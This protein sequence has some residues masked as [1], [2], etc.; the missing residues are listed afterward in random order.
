M[1]DRKLPTSS[2]IKLQDTAAQHIEHAHALLDVLN[3]QAALQSVAEIVTEKKLSESDLGKR[4]NIKSANALRITLLNTDKAKKDAV[5]LLRNAGTGVVTVAADAGDKLT[6]NPVMLTQNET[7]LLGAGPKE[8]HVLLRGSDVNAAVASLSTSV[9]T[10]LSSAIGSVSSL[11]TAVESKIAGLKTAL[12]SELDSKVIEKVKTQLTDAGFSK[13]LTAASTGRKL[14][15]VVDASIDPPS[16]V[17]FS[18][19]SNTNKGYADYEIEF[20]NACTDQAAGLFFGM[21]I[22]T[23]GSASWKQNGYALSQFQ[24]T[25]HG[26]TNAALHSDSA[27]ALTLQGNLSNQAKTSISGRI[28]LYAPKQTGL[29]H[30]FQMDTI[31]TL[32]AGQHIR[33]EGGCV[34]FADVDSY[35][36]VRL[37]YYPANGTPT[38][39]I[40]KGVFRLYGLT[41]SIGG[42]Q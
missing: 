38:G 20:S 8:W 41:N 5:V 24:E 14:L 27:S 32:K 2:D 12:A 9:S 29:F 26:E 16:S 11:S 3:T 15:Q 39:K 21:Q 19:S 13:T 18:L 40:T 22:S 6:P 25:A 42:N 23:D 33:T 28:R 1:A 37:F 7:V 36:K 35:D 10:A 17:E 30:H 34:F 4:I 31:A